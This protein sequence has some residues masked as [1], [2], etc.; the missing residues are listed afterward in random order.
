MDYYKD[1]WNHIISLIWLYFMLF[2][3]GTLFN[4][5]I[6][7]LLLLLFDR[8]N[9]NNQ[10][11]VP[12]F[13][14]LIPTL[15]LNFMQPYMDFKSVVRLFSFALIFL[16]FASYKGDRILFPYVLFAVCF[17]LL[18]Q[19]SIIFSLPYLASFFDST[20]HISELALQNHSVDM[21]NVEVAEVAVKTRLGGMFINPNNCASY[22]SVA[23]AVGLCEAERDTLKQKILFYLFI[24]ITII[25]TLITGSR[26]GFIVIA[27][28]TLYYL[29]SKGYSLRRYIILG[30]PLALLL[31]YEDLSELS[32]VRAFNV[33]EGM[34]GSVSAKMSIFVNYLSKCSNPI[35][36]LFGAGDIMVTVDVYK[37]GMEGTDM[38]F[39]NIFIVFGFFFYV[40]YV[41]ICI[42]IFRLLEPQYRVIMFVLLWSFSNSILISYRMCP[43]FFL[44][45]GLLYKRSCCAPEDEKEL[46]T[47]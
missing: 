5:S 12:L 3:T 37:L 18:S 6:P 9:R 4:I 44:A 39:G 31:L 35:W 29:Y 1:K 36:W 7:V 27:A 14:L 22:L 2:P 20:Y 43:I 46:C 17:I 38:D 24:A 8:Q 42:R 40:L 33:S 19:I 32:D 25:S 45:L 23:Y 41:S 26:T 30:I 16:T 47:C 15:A 10:I 21:S 11:L 34:E 13:I 28:I